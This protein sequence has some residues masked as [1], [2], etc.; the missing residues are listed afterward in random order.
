MAVETGA[1][2]R[3]RTADRPLTRS[4]HH[5]W[6]AAAFLV[7]GGLFVVWLS[8]DVF[9]FRP[10]LARGWHGAFWMQTIGALLLGWWKSSL[11]SMLRVAC[12]GTR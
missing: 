4:F 10:V 9:G 6:P 2:E 7:R 11:S 3:I 1:G 5:R 12:V 8:L